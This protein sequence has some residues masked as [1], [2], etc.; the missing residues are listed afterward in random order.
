MNM[1]VYLVTRENLRPILSSKDLF[2]MPVPC[3]S[4]F[5]AAI[6]AN[7]SG[8][9]VCLTCFT[10]RFNVWSPHLTI[11]ERSAR[12]FLLHRKKTFLLVPFM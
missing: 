1:E 10:E 8:L 5:A 4:R 12:S 6:L 9:A 3:L 7:F 2:S 11:T